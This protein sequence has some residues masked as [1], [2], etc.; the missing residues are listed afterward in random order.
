MNLPD[1]PRIWLT[2]QRRSRR[3]VIRYEDPDTGNIR[4]RSTRTTNEREAERQLGQ[5]RAD[6]K[7][8]RVRPDGNTSWVGFPAAI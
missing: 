4:Q 7:N 5:L 6:L 8:R 1:E 2:K 3:W